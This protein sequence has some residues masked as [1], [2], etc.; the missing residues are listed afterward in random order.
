MTFVQRRAASLAHDR[1]RGFNYCNTTTL[2]MMRRAIYLARM[3]PAARA[4]T[5]AVPAPAESATGGAK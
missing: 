3:F 1:A 5:A 2:A 4:A